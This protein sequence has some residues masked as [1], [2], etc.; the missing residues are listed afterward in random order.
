MPKSPR[1]R[2]HRTVTAG[3]R[4]AA[5]DRPFPSAHR[6]HIKTRRAVLEAEREEAAARAAEKQAAVTIQRYVRGREARQLRKRLKVARKT[7]AML[8]LGGA[9]KVKVWA[10]RR[11]KE[12]A[13]SF[14]AAI[15]LQAWRRGHDVRKLLRELREEGVEPWLV[16][17]HN[18]AAR[19]WFERYS[20]ARLSERGWLSRAQLHRMVL[21]LRASHGLPL[22]DRVVA[23]EVRALMDGSWD[24]D[25][26]DG[27]SKSTC[28]A[29]LYP[30]RLTWPRWLQI[31][32]AAEKR[33][34]P[35]AAHP[36]V[37]DGWSKTARWALRY[38]AIRGGDPC[39]AVGAN[40]F[41]PVTMPQVGAPHAPA[42][43][44]K[45]LA[46]AIWTLCGESEHFVFNNHVAKGR[47]GES[48][49]VL[50][51]PRVRHAW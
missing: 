16:S 23:A 34:V 1:Q 27:K 6:E 41:Y 17:G 14:D 31:V 30:D 4:L 15:K 26:V 22:M 24:L 51:R 5:A 32:R 49:G 39:L 8:T 33:K 37:P 18:S 36:P 3:C 29:R 43:M 28:S 2:Y 13:T 40:K 38:P 20:G 7:K 9:L 47:V 10:M 11:R 48:G 44:R 21:E 35:V 50:L 46:E 42:V 45:P 25:M 19:R 12:K